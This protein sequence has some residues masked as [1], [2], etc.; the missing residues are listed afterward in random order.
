VGELRFCPNRRFVELGG[1]A[2]I[3]PILKT[4]SGNHDIAWIS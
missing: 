2:A 3:R 4:Y 1:D